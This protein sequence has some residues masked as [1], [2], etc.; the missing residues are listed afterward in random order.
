ML[1]AVSV[2]AQ[3][4]IAY[5][6]V[7]FRGGGQNLRTTILYDDSPLWIGKTNM[8]ETLNFLAALGWEVDS[9]ISVE[10]FGFH[11]TRHKLHIILKKKYS[12]GENPF[13]GLDK[14]NNSHDLEE[15]SLS[16]NETTNICKQMQYT[17][18][19]EKVV[20]PNY[21]NYFGA[22][23]VLNT[24]ENG[25]GVIFF[26][27]LVSSI[28]NSAFQDCKSLTS[29]TIPDSVKKI[30]ERAFDGC[31][32]LKEIYCKPTTPP[33][34]DSYMFKN[35]A[36]GRKIYVPRASVEAYKAADGWKDDASYIVGY[37][38]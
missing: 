5:C 20:K 26:D 28:G 29:I 24:Y 10:R 14:F 31:T 21:S 12:E 27:A 13:E 37:D 18:S 4:K 38:F 16:N 9:N 8:G 25:Q 7:Y 17:S 2:N 19:D 6:D 22:R 3:T 23:I 32:S 11:I 15:N 35:N 33:T 36:S 34:G 30:G 1:C